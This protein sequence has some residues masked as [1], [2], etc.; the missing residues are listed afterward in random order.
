MIPQEDLKWGKDLEEEV[1]KFWDTKEIPKKARELRKGRKKFYF[2]DG[3]PYATEA[4][5]LG[6]VWNKI[7]KDTVLRYRR[8]RGYDTYDRPGYDTHGLPIEKKVEE[9]LGIKK[10]R[11][12]EEYGVDRF[13]EK[14]REYAS[15]Y[16]EVM[17]NQF[18]NVGV[19]MDWE[20]P[21]ITYKNEYI[22][23]AW[24]TFKKAHERGLL[25]KDKYPVHVCP[26][27]ETVEAYNELEYK[28]LEDPSI[29]VKFPVLGVPGTF[30][31]IWTTTPWTLPANVAVMA[32][33]DYEYAKVKVG[34]EILILAKE[35]VEEV[36]EKAGI[37]KY[38]IVDVVKGENLDGLRYENPLAEYVPAQRG[39]DHR[40]VMSKRFVN[41]EEGTG[42][43]HSAPGHGREDF[44]VAKEYNLPVVCFVGM[45]G[46]YGEGAG[47]YKGKMVLE[48]NEEIIEDLK[49]LGFLFHEE[50]IVHSYPTCW[51]CKRRTIITS[52]EEWFF[53]VDREK[54]REEIKKVKWVPRWVGKRMENWVE[55]LGDWPVSRQ[56]YWGIPLPIWVCEKC[57]HVEVVGSREE[58]RALGAEVPEDLHKPHIDR[59]TLTCPRCGGEM[60][61][62]PEVLDVWFDSGVAPWG[63]LDFP[64]RRD[65][66]HTFWPVDYEI[67][68]PDQIRGWWNSQL[69]NGVI[70]FDEVPYRT[71]AMHGFILDVHGVKMSKS[72]GNVVRAE[73]IIEKY[74]RDTLRAYLLGVSPG[75]DMYFSWE[76]VRD[77]YKRLNIFWNVY[78]F[79]T[80]FLSMEGFDPK[81]H[82]IETRLPEDLWIKSRLNTVLQAVLEN[83]GEY[84]LNRALDLLLD[85]TVDDLSRTYLKLAKERIK[86]P[87]KDPRKASAM[88]TLYE[89]LTVLIRAL[90]PFVP[91]MTERMYQNLVRPVDPDAPESVHLTDYPEPGERN[92]ELERY[93]DIV[94]EIVDRVLEVRQREKVRLRWP[95]KPII[96]GTDDPTVKKAVETFS[97]A[98]KIL[99][100]TKGVVV[101]DLQDVKEGEGFSRGVV[102]VDTSMTP[103][104][105]S[106]ATAREVIRRFQQ[107]R[108]EMGLVE[109]ARV[110]AEVVAP[111]EILA[112]IE[113]WR[114]YIASRIGATE[115]FLSISQNI[116]GY[117]RT[118][119]VNGKEMKLVL[120][121]T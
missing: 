66:F 117:E 7:L 107:M 121:S 33:P 2:L 91:F 50:K 26:Y 31:L 103:E 102:V 22:E 24:Y 17:N 20:N 12:I 85:F 4:A 62:T 65:L 86:L 21:Y 83:M 82:D 72:L 112:L 59:V 16:I 92:E 79:A 68:G 77:A 119:K 30:L 61:R 60:R 118:W 6:T 11:E 96:V 46:R 47:K 111:E 95:I 32:H 115:L 73:D 52:V 45:D 9:E 58:L 49:E 100:N 104:L 51:R 5:H 55:S 97:E 76:G 39:L 54:L 44:L 40:V 120:R 53:K 71:V 101:R 90:A 25:Y 3:P 87:G 70:T 37:E 14:C 67:E 88:R 98:I 109:K 57:G 1:L 64:H 43:V 28:D 19:W 78:L 13:I 114:E 89:V 48:A 41:L 29:Y 74:N 106:E 80:R 34:N 63:A 113:D 108:K 105:V 93:M 8:M 38:E 42:L 110:I 10:K 94:H 27:C 81:V 23:A 15:R 116:E 84:K 36:M 35:K 18:R 69:I 75:E 56:R 99:A